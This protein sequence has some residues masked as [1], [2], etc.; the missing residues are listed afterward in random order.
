MI[1]LSKIRKIFSYKVIK[2][3]I[4][5]DMLRNAYST[6]S[7]TGGTLRGKTAVVTG[8]TSG[9]GFATAQRLLSEG[10]NVIIAGR[11]EDKLK[12]S[13]LMFK[14]DGNVKIDYIIL[15]ALDTNSFKQ[16]VENVFEYDTVDIWVNCAGVLKKSDRERKFRGVDA[17]TYFD[18]VNTNLK[19]NMLLIPLV[20]D[21]MVARGIN[22]TIISVSSICGFTNHFGYTPY[23]ISKNGLIEYTR[24]IADKY[25]GKISILSVAPGSVATRMGDTGYGKNISG[26]TSFTHHIAIP[27]ETAAV[28]AFLISPIGSNLNGQTIL[29]SAG[30]KI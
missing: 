13:I 23:G 1:F 18:V 22:G 8:G 6:T 11:N 4:Y 14:T 15:D 29:A 17:E 3:L 30:E 7:V 5:D 16:K 28:I 24:Q 2:P 12:D 10:C 25:K 20:A 26:S 21:A 27:E 9:I 19:S